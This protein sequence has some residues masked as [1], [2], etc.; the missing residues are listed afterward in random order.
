MKILFL[1]VFFLFAKIKLSFSQQ[2]CWMLDFNDPLI[3]NDFSECGVDCIFP[4]QE[5]YNSNPPTTFSPTSE[6]YL[7][8]SLEWN[9]MESKTLWHP[10]IPKTNYVLEMAVNLVPLYTGFRFHLDGDDPEDVLS[11]DIKSSENG[12]EVLKYDFKLNYFMVNRR[13]SVE[14]WVPA[15]DHPIKH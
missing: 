1:C 6:R 13:V 4:S 12:W 11:V 3:M 10:K 9:C 2:D 15:S 8:P 14:L 5:M 7:M